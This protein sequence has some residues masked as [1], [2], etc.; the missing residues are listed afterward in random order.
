MDG[1]GIYNDL[2]G[3]ITN[4]WI[5]DIE[6]FELPENIAKS[7]CYSLSYENDRM[8]EWLGDTFW[9]EYNPVFCLNEGDYYVSGM[10]LF[11]QILDEFYE[12]SMS[13]YISSWKKG[14]DEFI[15]RSRL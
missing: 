8:M 4:I 5:N 12:P 1:E 9:V 13:K 3:S 14:L 6:I 2:Y 10:V 11:N 15:E 7:I